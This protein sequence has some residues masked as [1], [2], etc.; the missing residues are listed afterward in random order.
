MTTAGG[1]KIA[2]QTG[3]RRFVEACKV[4]PVGTVGQV[5]MMLEAERA[6]DS[7]GGLICV[8]ERLKIVPLPLRPPE[9]AVPYSVLPARIKCPIGLAPSLLVA[10]LPTVAVKLYRVVNPVPFVLIV[11]IVP[12]PELPP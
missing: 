3:E 9:A 12:F 6:K 11:N 2:V 5:K 8:K 7:L 1:V 10:A 4:K